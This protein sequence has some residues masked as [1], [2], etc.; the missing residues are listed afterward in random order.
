MQ[1]K[2][3]MASV[4]QKNTSIVPSVQIH[5][6]EEL[7]DGS[8]QKEPWIVVYKVHENRVVK[9]YMLFLQDKHCYKPVPLIGIL[10]KAKICNIYSISDMKCVLDMLQ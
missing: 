9:I 5:N 6:V 1:K 7:R 3:E 2:L 10:T 8:I 4:F